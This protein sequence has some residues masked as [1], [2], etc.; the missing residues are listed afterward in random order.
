MII[1]VR[2]VY[3]VSDFRSL[4]MTSTL[5]RKLRGLKI[6]KRSVIT[7]LSAIT[8][9]VVNFNEERDAVEVPVRLEN[10]N[11]LWTEFN[12]IQADME[13]L[14]GT[15]EAQEA[16]LKER[17]EIEKAYYRAKGT[18]MFKTNALNDSQSNQPRFQEST[19]QPQIKLPEVK[20]P[21]FSG[22]FDNWLNF[23]DLFLSLVHTSTHLSTIQKFYYLRSSLSDEA[24]KLPYMQRSIS[25]CMENVSGPFSEP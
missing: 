3:A 16:L 10:L 9:F 7:S 23:H 15:E 14:E 12:R 2:P 25:S 24:L 22:E 21:T 4:I 20:L 18:L 13:Q 17:T 8:S 11:S 19:H 5:E 1:L 6:R